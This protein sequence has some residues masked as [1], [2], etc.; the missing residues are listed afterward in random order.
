MNWTEIRFLVKDERLKLT[1]IKI[2]LQIN[3][4]HIYF[5]INVQYLIE[6][7]SLCYTL[8]HECIYLPK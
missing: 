5:Y 7:F 2:Y 8:F 1:V 4:V 3:I 6:F